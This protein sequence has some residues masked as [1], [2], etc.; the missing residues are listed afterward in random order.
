MAAAGLG[1]HTSCHASTLYTLEVSGSVLEVDQETGLATP[2]LQGLAPGSWSGLAASPGNRNELF[3]LYNPTPPTFDDPQFSGL[4][5]I[6]LSNGTATLLPFFSA[7]DLG[8]NDEIFSTGIAIS[9]GAPDQAI[10]IGSTAKKI[11]PVPLIWTVDLFSGRVVEPARPLSNVSRLES[12][13]FGP[14]GTSL[15]AANQDGELVSI[16]KQSAEVTLIGDPDL[17][18]SL[19]GLAFRPEDQTL[20]AIDARREDKLVI[21][22]PADGRHLATL[23]KLGIAGPEGLAFVPSGDPLDCSLDGIVNALDL[24]CANSAGIT[25]QLLQ[26]LGLFA[27]DLDG[28]DGVSFHDFLVL[29]DNYGQPKGKYTEGDINGNG[30]VDFGDFVV[31]A[32]N[33]GKRSL[34][35]E[36]V[37]E[38]ASCGSLLAGSLVSWIL[39][40]RRRR[41]NGSMPVGRNP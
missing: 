39:R 22:D 24:D 12:L 6:D 14:D 32:D 21:L 36:A 37:P 19:S 16:N 15:F 27:G 2:I 11:P 1:S 3:A 25:S 4:S 35:A 31:L 9:A 17:S 30:E 26:E 33:Y 40:R 7:E 29:A 13:T 41:V 18:L 28:M 20:F 5:R 10:V 8:L 34:S 23:G 38:P